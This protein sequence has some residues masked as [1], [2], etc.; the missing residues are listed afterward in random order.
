MPFRRACARSL[1]LFPF[2]VFMAAAPHAP[3]QESPYFLTYTH[4]MEEPGSLEVAVNPVL[5]FP[6]GGASRFLASSLEVEYGVNGWWTSELYLDGQKTNRER[7]VFTGYRFENRFR[8]LMK[9]H[10]VNPVLYIEYEDITGADKIFKEIVG[11][12]T[13]HGLLEPAED[14]RR[15]KKREV[16][17]KLIL[18]SNVRGWNL[19][20]NLIAEKNLNGE[21]IEFGYAA[22]ISRPLAL[23]ASPSP[24]SLCREN[25]SLGIE[26]YG[27]LGEQHQVTLSGT[28]HYLA[29]VVAWSLPNGVTLRLSPSI[30]INANSNRALVRFGIAYEFP[31]IPSRT[32]AQ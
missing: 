22:G 6:K 11:F 4:H 18:S 8:L 20:G 31:V 19:A 28:S 25:F 17:A 27:G 26:L 29:P 14:L 15:E 12:D 13:F 23:A 10:A 30:G 7:S 5:G 2:L 21:P 1:A 32:I 16:E 9:E 3:A 24:C